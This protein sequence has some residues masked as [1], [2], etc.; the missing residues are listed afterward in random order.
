[1]ALQHAMPLRDPDTGKELSG[2]AR[3]KLRA[4]R[5]AP[6]KAPAKA[7]KSAKKPAPEPAPAQLD[8]DAA[9]DL[10]PFVDLPPPPE[11]TSKLVTWAAQACGKV[12]YEASQNPAYYPNRREW[13]KAI[14]AAAGHLGHIRDK[15]IEQEKI[16]AAL[17]RDER[18]S[19]R[20]GL[21]SAIGRKAEKVTRPPS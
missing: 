4:A 15:A 6:D 19:K 5:D 7:A 21:S 11:D 10:G 14:G 1:M 13:L 2:A 12:L 18:A 3:R 20:Q 9:P 8:L 17:R 16:D